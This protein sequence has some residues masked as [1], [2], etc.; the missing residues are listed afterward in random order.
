MQ[1]EYGINGYFPII[2]TKG[3]YNKPLDIFEFGKRDGVD[4]IRLKL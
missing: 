2:F 4:A 1:L 3:V